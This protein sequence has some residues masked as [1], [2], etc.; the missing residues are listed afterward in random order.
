MTTIIAIETADKITLGW[1]SRVTAGRQRSTIDASK[2][3]TNGDVTILFSGTV[4][5]LHI[6][7]YAKLPTLDTWDVDRWMTNQ[8]TPTIRAVLTGQEAA[9]LLDGERFMGNGLLVVAGGRVYEVEHHFGWYRRADGIYTGGSGY[10]YAIGALSAGATVR[11]A[12][13]VAATHDNATGDELHV[14]E[15]DRQTS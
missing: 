1:D 9:T 3:F 15:I 14:L 2:M 6:L 12:L 11:Q 8:F 7:K 13:E 10:Q 5:D 4:R